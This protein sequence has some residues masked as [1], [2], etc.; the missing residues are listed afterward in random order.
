MIW[1]PVSTHDRDES[2]ALRRFVYDCGEFIALAS[3]SARTKSPKYGGLTAVCG[4]ERCSI[5]AK[6]Y[7]GKNRG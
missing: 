3:L 1:P 6:Q 4:T 2:K 5:D 7:R